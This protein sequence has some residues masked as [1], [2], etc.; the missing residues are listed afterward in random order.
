MKNKTCG[1]CKY[2]KPYNEKIC[3]YVHRTCVSPKTQACRSFAKP[4]LFDRITQSPERL[5]PKLVYWTL[6][7]YDG[8]IHTHWMSTITGEVIYDS[9]PEAIAAT[10]AK[11]KEV[12]NE[13]TSD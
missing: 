4:T 9:E 11:L 6:I 3:L 2:Y 10:V 8:K 13:T 7:E 5:A 12:Y 1:E